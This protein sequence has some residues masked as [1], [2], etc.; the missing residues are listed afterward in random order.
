MDESILR[1]LTKDLNLHEQ[2]IIDLLFLYN[3]SVLKLV[4]LNLSD[5]IF[6]LNID[7]ALITLQGELSMISGESYKLLVK[8]LL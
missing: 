3:I 4:D 6:I 7:I 1:K 2:L 5:V 8:C